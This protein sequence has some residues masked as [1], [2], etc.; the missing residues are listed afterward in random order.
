MRRHTGCMEDPMRTVNLAAAAI[1]TVVI[2]AC[3]PQQAP[4]NPDAAPAVAKLLKVQSSA[5]AA[6]ILTADAIVIDGNNRFSGSDAADR[7]A[8]IAGDLTLASG[9]DSHHDVLRAAVK[10]GGAD[11]ML[12]GGLDGKRLRFVV[13][14]PRPKD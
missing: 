6:A 9:V 13:L 8:S 11:A 10:N 12:F 14:L 3:G 7:I 4:P 5:D 2:A 1:S